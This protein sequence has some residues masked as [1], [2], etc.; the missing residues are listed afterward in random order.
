VLSGVGFGLVVWVGL[1][2]GG[3]IVSMV[4]VDRV[5]CG[6]TYLVIGPDMD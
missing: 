2:G 5:R 6:Q 1:V 4:R 3:P